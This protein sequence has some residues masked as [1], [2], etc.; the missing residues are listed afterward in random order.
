[1]CLW[2][3]LQL[4]KLLPLF[5]PAGAYGVG[6]DYDGWRREGYIAATTYSMVV[7][8]GLDASEAKLVVEA[9]E[10]VLL[11]VLPLPEALVAELTRGAWVERA[12]R[13]SGR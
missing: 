8:V 2:R 3:T 1:M 4:H 10:V 11:G 13:G 12:A 9:Y 6:G 7:I 5:E